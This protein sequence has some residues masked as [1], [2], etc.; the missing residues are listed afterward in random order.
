M[1]RRLTW[2]QYRRMWGW[3]EC[4]DG[5]RD[6]WFPVGAEARERAERE[7]EPY[8]L[9]PPHCRRTE[10]VDMSCAPTEGAA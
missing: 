2:P 10:D 9:L 6:W 5:K 1:L 7:R 4:R 8:H 3:P